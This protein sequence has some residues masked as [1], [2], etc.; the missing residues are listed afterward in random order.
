MI[1]A[2]SASKAMIPRLSA[3]LF[4]SGLSEA[5]MYVVMP[6]TICDRAGAEKYKN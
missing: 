1:Q 4:N 2:R 6:A 3:I 5:G